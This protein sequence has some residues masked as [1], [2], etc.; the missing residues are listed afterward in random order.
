M[1]QIENGF[2]L[3]RMFRLNMFKSERFL[4]W[5]IVKMQ[6][7]AGDKSPHLYGRIDER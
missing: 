5:P 2:H 1:F 6:V 3:F 7:F 4:H